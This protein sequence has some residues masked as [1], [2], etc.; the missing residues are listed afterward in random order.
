MKFL[1]GTTVRVI[2]LALLFVGA[3][4]AWQADPRPAGNE[5]APAA[6]QKPASEATQ[7]AAAQEGQ[8]S[9]GEQLAEA[10]KEAEEGA[11]FKHSKAVKWISKTFGIPPAVEYWVLYGIDFGI[12]AGAIIWMM[13]KKLPGVF[14]TKNEAIRRSME[15]AARVSAE[16]RARL[17]EIESRLSRLD[18]EIVEMKASAEADARQEEARILAAAEEDKQRIIATAEQEIVAASKLA[19]RELKAYAAALAVDIAQQRVKVDAETDRAL[20]RNFASQ[21][22]KDGQ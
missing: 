9:S 16:A 4:R 11:Q 19:Q 21:F 22:G 15:E 6:E 12:V 14:R 18:S 7:E 1:R 20:V 8:R 3:A 5:P 13:K 2:L 10:S 17:S